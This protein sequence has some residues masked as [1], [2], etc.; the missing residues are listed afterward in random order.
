MFKNSVLLF[1]TFLTIGC[2]STEIKTIRLS[3]N[4]VVQKVPGKT[5]LPTHKTTAHVG[6]VMFTAGEYSKEASTLKSETFSIAESHN[7]Y[8][9]HRR[10]IVTYYLKPMDFFLYHE[11]NHGSYYKAKENVQTSEKSNSA[12]IGL[13]VPKGTNEATDFFWNWHPVNNPNFYQTKLEKPIKG[14][15]NSKIQYF[16]DSYRSMTP[17]AT[18]TYSGVSS[19]Q[20]R[21]T[22]NEFTNGGYIKPAFTQEVNL[23]YKPNGIYS[24]KSA[25]F[26]VYKA[27]S[28]HIN[29]EIIKPLD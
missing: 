24:Y 21:F 10:K 2:S 13:Y 1:F 14:T 9:K 22:Y 17:S 4:I 6:E 25:L 27:D 15:K 20:I 26:K 8:A 3:P 16:N 5:L 18:V 29:F 7:V 19:G 11:N 12:F 23:D 28:A